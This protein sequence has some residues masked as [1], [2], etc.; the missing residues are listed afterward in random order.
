MS[1]VTGQRPIEVN[2]ISWNNDGDLFFLTIGQ[3][4]INILSY[5]DLKLQHTLNAFPAN[6]I[7][8]EFDPKGKYYA[9]GSADA[10]INIWDVAELACIRSF[11][12]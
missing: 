10:L 7:C 5:T 9:T 4:S 11:S 1:E 3:G 2:E 8:I 6:C 12:K